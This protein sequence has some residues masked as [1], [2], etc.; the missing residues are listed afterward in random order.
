MEFV[1]RRLEIAGVQPDGVFMLGSVAY[2]DDHQRSDFH[3]A[4][5]TNC[6]QQWLAKSMGQHIIDVIS[7]QFLRAAAGERPVTG[8]SGSR[9]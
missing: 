9:Q 2:N 3:T 1:R 4:A 8:G 5:I 6:D 7:D